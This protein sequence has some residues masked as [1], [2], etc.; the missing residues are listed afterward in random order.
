MGSALG[1]RIVF[2]LPPLFVQ[3]HSTVR[4]REWH[5]TQVLLSIFSRFPT[6]ELVQELT[7]SIV[8]IRVESRR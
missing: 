6:V 5:S 7:K 2:G 8:P 4:Q 3:H 1:N